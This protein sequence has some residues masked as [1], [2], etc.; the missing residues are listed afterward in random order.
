MAENFGRLPLFFTEN[1]GQINPQV[2][3]YT[4]GQGHAIFFTPE[5]MVLSLKRASGEVKKRG[6][7]KGKGTGDQEVVQLRPQG[8]SPGA[9]ILATEPLPGKVNYYQGND[10][11]KWRTEVPTYKSV[12]YR[13][14]YPGIDLKFYGTGHSRWNTTSLSN[15]GRI[16]NRSNSS[17]RGLRP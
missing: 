17:T 12:L 1:L 13:E 2:K 3:F 9:E 16:P 5:A 7:K 8:I 14:A 15:P 6:G 4:R 10:P 11:A